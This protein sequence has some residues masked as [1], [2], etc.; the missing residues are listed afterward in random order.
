MYLV[1]GHLIYP[2]YKYGEKITP[3]TLINIKYL[4]QYIQ[5]PAKSFGESAMK[6][7]LGQLQI[8]ETQVLTSKV[9]ISYDKSIIEIFFAYEVEKP[10]L[11]TRP[12]VTITTPYH[13][14]SGYAAFNGL[15]IPGFTVLTNT[16]DTWI[17]KVMKTYYIDSFMVKPVTAEYLPGLI[18]KNKVKDGTLA[19]MRHIPNSF[20]HVE[21]FQ[22]L[23]WNI[24]WYQ[25]TNGS[26]KTIRRPKTGWPK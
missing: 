17:K 14:F 19:D 10:M 20:Q 1:T 26:Q 4:N 2:A 11:N 25:E 16:W 3:D 15:I 22:K 9:G 7:L 12:D 8:P 5:A 24:I 23:N 21:A 13:S 18:I 6:I